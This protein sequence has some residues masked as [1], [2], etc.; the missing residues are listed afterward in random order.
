MNA[1]TKIVNNKRP[2][3]GKLKIPIKNKITYENFLKDLF[4]I[5]RINLTCP[6]ESYLTIVTDLF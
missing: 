1:M 6:Q 2:I 4:L 5:N 3:E